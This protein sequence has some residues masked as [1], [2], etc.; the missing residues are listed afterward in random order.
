MKYSI[1]MPVKNEED[2]IGQALQILFNQTVAPDEVV[3]TDAG[4]TDGTL[5]IL[6]DLQKVHPN[7]FLI[8]RN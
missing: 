1:I 2:N 4:S 3:V 7:L 5:A 6:R 8:S